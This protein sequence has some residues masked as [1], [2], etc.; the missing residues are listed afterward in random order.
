MKI[1][2]VA[3]RLDH[4]YFFI[5]Y[6]QGGFLYTHMPDNSKHVKDIFIVV[7]AVGSKIPMGEDD[8]IEADFG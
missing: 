3:D 8:I 4:H 6:T 2:R 5:V 7:K 1:L